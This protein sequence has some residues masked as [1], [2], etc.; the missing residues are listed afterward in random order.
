MSFISSIISGVI[1]GIFSPITSFFKFRDYIDITKLI[2]DGKVNVALLEASVQI[3]RENARLLAN[4]VIV[5][6]QVL[7]A[8]PLAFY[9]GKIHI[10]DTALHL[11]H[12]DTIVGNVATG[13][14][15]ILG[16][17]FLHSAITNLVNK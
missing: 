12:T 5:A 14:T 2:E 10:W 11:G 6:L 7:F 9:Y 16:F 3:A 17:L 13:D 4:K 1:S 8:V 15:W